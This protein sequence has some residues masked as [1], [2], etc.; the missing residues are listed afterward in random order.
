MA[1]AVLAGIL[2]A[3]AGLT[4]GRGL[5]A[6]I[7]LVIAAAGALGLWWL[8]ET[9]LRGARREHAILVELNESLDEQV[10]GRTQRLMQTIE[11][12]E[13]FNRMVTHDLRSPLSGLILGIELLEEDL[14]KR[15]DPPLQA[16]VKTIAEC[17][18]R[19]Q[20]LVQD[21]RQLALISGRAPVIQEVDLSHY[22]AVILRQLAQKEPNRRVSWT[23]E[24]KLVVYGDSS[25]L[26]I[27]LENLLGNAWKYT[28]DRN[29]A[30]IVMRRGHGEGVVLEIQD[31]GTGFD[32]AK[33][34]RLFQPFQRMHEDARY[35]GHGIGLS[36]VKRVM[37]RH[38][39]DISAIS[40][41]GEGA[42][43]RL[44]F[45]AEPGACRA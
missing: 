2:V 25:L 4:L 18:Q 13:S 38:N 42:T 37:T 24:P 5:A 10:Q 34:D 43:F 7:G 28:L 27:A 9:S 44:H 29:P 17:A 32:M 23:I 26:R 41:P 36:I 20:D 12:M 39:G 35:P 19:M 30:E 3:G 31:N 1:L 21:L 16:R 22:A 40:A 15:P 6:G 11:D 8:A 33:A 45:P 14:R